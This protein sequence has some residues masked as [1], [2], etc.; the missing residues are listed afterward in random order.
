MMMMCLFA[1][2]AFVFVALC[3]R[4]VKGR[5][6]K[7]PRFL[8]HCALHAGRTA[9]LLYLSLLY[10]VGHDNRLTLTTS[11]RGQAIGKVECLPYMIDETEGC[12]C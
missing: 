7:A 5:E 6:M 11:G 9:L 3:T 1:F 4:K 12:W 8:Y 2:V 10:L